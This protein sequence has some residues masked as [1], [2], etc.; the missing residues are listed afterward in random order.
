MKNQGNI[1]YP[2]GKIKSLKK[3]PDGNPYPYERSFDADGGIQDDEKADGFNS[4]SYE[5]SDNKNVG[6]DGKG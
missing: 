1:K 5:P 4:F 3:M 6:D 2:E